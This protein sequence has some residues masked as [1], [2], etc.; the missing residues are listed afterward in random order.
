MARKKTPQKVD[1][2]AEAAIACFTDLGIRRTQMADVAKVAG[3]SAGT[4]YLYVTSKEALFH[5]AILKV[6]ARPLEN[7]AFPLA[8]PGMKATAAIFAARIAEVRHW[9]A[10]DEAL[11]PNAKAGMETLRQ[12]GRELYD[13]L[14]EARRAIW[15][16]DQCSSEIAEFEQ[17]HARDLRARHRDQLAEAAVKAAGRKAAP[18]PALILAARLGIEVVAWAAMHR[19]RESP[20]NFIRGLSEADA[21]ETAARSFATMLISAAE[22]E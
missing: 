20:V 17:M 11:K 10:L 14:S 15:L 7:L 5:L 21:R 3:V 2:I 4:L 12:I 6:C 16:V 19:L 1:D 22:A 9:P 8:D 18:S 13:M